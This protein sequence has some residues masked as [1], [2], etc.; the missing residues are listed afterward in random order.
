MAA[1]RKWRVDSD[2]CIQ[3]MVSWS[4]AVSECY[5]VTMNGSYKVVTKS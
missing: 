4:A 2:S 1:Y 5:I 3:G